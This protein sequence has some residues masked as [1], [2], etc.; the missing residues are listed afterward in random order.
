MS[1][2]PPTAT[3]SDETLAASKLVLND[4]LGAL[5]ASYRTT[6]FFVERDLVWTT[7]TWL[8]REVLR[9]GLDITVSTE[10]PIEPGERRAFS[11]DLALRNS[12]R[13]VIAVVEFK[14]EPN[15]ARLDVPKSK[16]PVVDWAAVVRDSERVRRWCAEHRCAHGLAVFVDEGGYFRH[17]P[18]PDG[19]SWHDW[20]DA[21]VSVLITRGDA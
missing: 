18:P 5:R 2:V 12:A 11:A 20:S 19:A 17:R 9:R 16:L 3:C 14:Y 4:A 13:A 8:L 15:H 6:A 7:Q 1:D 10:H 21:G